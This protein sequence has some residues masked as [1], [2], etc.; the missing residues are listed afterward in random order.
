MGQDHGAGEFQIGK[1]AL[2][3]YAWKRLGGDAV[4]CLSDQGRRDGAR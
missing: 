4:E 3:H 2:D 1:R